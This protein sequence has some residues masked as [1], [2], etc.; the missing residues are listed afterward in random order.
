MKRIIKAFIILLAP[1]LFLMVGCSNNENYEFKSTDVEVIYDS[2]TLVELEKP[3]NLNSRDELT[4]FLDYVIFSGVENEYIYTTVSDSYKEILLENLDYESRWAGQYGMLAHNF[5]IDYDFSKLNEGIV[6]AYGYIFTY[7]TLKNDRNAYT[8]E[9]MD[10]SYYKNIYL[11]NDN[12]RGYSL[13][14]FYLYKNNKGYLRVNNSEQLFYAIVNGYMPY[15]EDS[16]LLGL[17]SKILGIL[18]RILKPGMSEYERYDRMY[19]YLTNNVLYD[20]KMLNNK[21]G[22]PRLY[23]CYYLEG[24]ILDGLA[25]CDGLTKALAVFCSLEGI[26]T[27]HVG[28]V[29]YHGGHAYNYTSID[30]TWYL[31][32]VTNGSKLQSYKGRM[33]LTHTRMFFLSDLKPNPS[34]EFDSEFNEPIK[35][36]ITKKYNY[37]GN[38]KIDI[39]GKGYSLEALNKS[40]GLAILNYLDKLCN[41]NKISLD[42]ELLIDYDTYKEMEAAFNFKCEVDVINNGVFNNKKLYSFVFL[43]D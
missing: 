6:G 11:D 39:D 7:A 29:S 15:I 26:N 21:E 13:N 18:N 40:D 14:D 38:T 35:N 23:R 28:A 41:K 31:S 33:F 24:A 22:E 2:P 34:W 27:M 32:C 36:Q 8:N 42:I 1:F 5:L 30:D 4:A 19:S 10:Y 16:E 12:N 9:V 25:T 20:Y 43:G 37:W 3:R 17:F